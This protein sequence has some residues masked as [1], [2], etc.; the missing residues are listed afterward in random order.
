MQLT[1]EDVELA[2]RKLK[3]YVY[4]DKT[5]LRLRSRLAAFEQVGDMQANFFKIVDLINISDSSIQMDF[6]DW[7]EN[8]SFRIV[9]KHVAEVGHGKG[10]ERAKSTFI[11]NVS[12]ASTYDVTSVNY[13]FDGPIELQLIAVLWIMYV[14][15][16]L[17]DSLGKECYGSRLHPRVTVPEDKSANLF[18]KYHEQYESWRDTGIKTAK[19]LLTDEK[20]S[21]YI[22]GMD[23]EKYFYHIKFDFGVIAAEIKQISGMDSQIPNSLNGLLEIIHGAYAN[24]IKEA[25]EITHPNITSSSCIPIGLCSSPIL[26]NWHL[27]AFDE[28]VKKFVR[29]AYYGRYIDDILMVFPY[30]EEDTMAKEPIKD[31]MN[32]LFVKNNILLYDQENEKYTTVSPEGLILQKSKCI[33]QY[34]DALHSIAALE[35]FKKKLDENASNFLLLPVD[36]SDTTIEDVAYDLL[37]DGSVNKFRSVKG[38]AEN[39]FELAKHLARQTILHL[40]TNDGH[41]LNISA[42]L[43][44][45]FKGRNTIVF[46][47]LWE[48]VFTYLFVCDDSKSYELFARSIEKEIKR[49]K[50]SVNGNVNHEITQRLGDDLVEHKRLAQSITKALGDMFQIEGNADDQQTKVN[51]RKT[52]L[53]RNHF[54]KEPLLNYTTFTGDMT[55]ALPNNDMTIELDKVKIDWSP[56]FVHLSECLSLFYNG[57]LGEEKHSAYLKALEFYKSINHIEDSTGLFFDWETSEKRSNDEL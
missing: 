35:K 57:S 13:F 56:R 20:Q 18:K 21:V 53:I 34:F 46:Y 41:N 54:I 50:F 47:E 4:Y 42:S 51:F 30:N 26:A 27:K 15:K 6:K 5:D 14:G 29:P 25:L 19:R 43:M 39:R 49:T 12:S 55:K 16:H 33:L 36:E 23:L 3:K 10:D 22:L 52:N 32:L 7:C 9:P 11:S 2:Y 48:R 31:L 40:Q 37:Y 8:I 45:F 17:D 24:C 1:I 44:K 28:L 38:M